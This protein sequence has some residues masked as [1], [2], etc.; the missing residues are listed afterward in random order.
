MGQQDSIIFILD[1]KSVIS[2]VLTLSYPK[3]P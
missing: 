1:S 3:L 2:V